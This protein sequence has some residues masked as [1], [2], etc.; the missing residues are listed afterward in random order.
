M[1]GFGGLDP[2]FVG[3]LVA[4]LLFVFFAYLFVRRTLVGLREGYDRGRRE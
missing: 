2:V 3:L 4:M 1:A